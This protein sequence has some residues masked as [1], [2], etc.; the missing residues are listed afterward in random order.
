[1]NAKAKKLLDEIEEDTELLGL[2]YLT[3]KIKRLKVELTPAPKIQKS[4]KDNFCV[5]VTEGKLVNQFYFKQDKEMETFLKNLKKRH[6][7]KLN[8]FFKSVG[9]VRF[10]SLNS[11]RESDKERYRG[12][13]Q[14]HLKLIADAG[15]N[16]DIK[17]LAL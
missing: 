12:G 16:L 1:M 9:G 3:A 2:D 15:L 4:Q 17:I 6:T 10:P 11:T 8:A 7:V 5:Y 14:A 13:V